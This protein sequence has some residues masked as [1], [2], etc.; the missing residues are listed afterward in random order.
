MSSL[1]HP[2]SIV[3]HV[4]SSLDMHVLS[5]RFVGAPLCDEA[6]DVGI[7]FIN[8]QSVTTGGH[9]AFGSNI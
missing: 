9:E 3:A 7:D 4:R 6:N 1:Q 5:K 2:V 8:T